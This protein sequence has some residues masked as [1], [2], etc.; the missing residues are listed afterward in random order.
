MA[1]K[2]KEK[3]IDDFFNNEMAKRVEDSFSD[4]HKW[5]ESD[6]LSQ[7]R[8]HIFNTWHSDIYQKAEKAIEE[9]AGGLDK[10]LNPE[11]HGEKLHEKFANII[12][13][14]LGKALYHEHD[15]IE[16]EE[17]KERIKE[18]GLKGKELFQEVSR[19]YNH[20]TG[21]D[22][23]GRGSTRDYINLP[24]LLESSLQKNMSGEEV[25]GLLQDQHIHHVKGAE[26]AYDQKMWEQKVDQKVHPTETRMYLRKKIMPQYEAKIS[27]KAMFHSLDKENSYNLWQ[28]LTKGKQ[29]SHDGRTINYEQLGVDYKP[30]KAPQD[31][32]KK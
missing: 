24:A 5:R 4:Y 19:F 23:R 25:L 7:K 12:L 31:D 14:Y 27:N 21:A 11:K 28:G 18:Q 17:L 29:T 13:G 2:K 1:D 15:N 8:R 20:H 16:F 6:D 26:I 30:L 9:V 32:K 10:K 22:E 3:S